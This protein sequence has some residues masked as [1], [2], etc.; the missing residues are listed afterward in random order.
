LIAG[1][2]QPILNQLRPELHFAR[3]KRPDVILQ[4]AAAA[5]VLEGSFATGAALQEVKPRVPRPWTLFLPG[6]AQR[7]E[8]EALCRGGGA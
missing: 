1:L 8:W 6:V 2:E 5:P 4:L 3:A 7:A